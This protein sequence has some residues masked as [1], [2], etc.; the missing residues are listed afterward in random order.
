[1]WAVLCVAYPNVCVTFFN[2]GGRV[3]LVVGL[4]TPLC[5]T[6]VGLVVYLSSVG[7]AAGFVM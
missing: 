2:P 5:V 6:Y 3:Y 7:C 1:M 4:N